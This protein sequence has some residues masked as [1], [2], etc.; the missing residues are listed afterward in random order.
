MSKPTGWTCK[1]VGGKAVPNGNC[2][3]A[4]CHAVGESV[5]ASKYEVFYSHQYT[6][7]VLVEACSKEEAEGIVDR[8]AYDAQHETGCSELHSKTQSFDVHSVTA[9]EVKP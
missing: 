2:G 1:C 4:L 5:P 8:L 3:E 9:H 6:A 7:I